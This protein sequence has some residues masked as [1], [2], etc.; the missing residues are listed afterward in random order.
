MHHTGHGAA[1]ACTGCRCSR[2]HT[3]VGLQAVHEGL[4]W[5]A[6]RLL[7]AHKSITKHLPRHCQQRSSTHCPMSA[8]MQH[9]SA[10]VRSAPGQP[11]WDCCCTVVAG[12]PR[13]AV[14]PLRP[15]RRRSA[16][17]PARPPPARGACWRTRGRW[18]RVPGRCP[19]RL[20]CLRGNSR[21]TIRV[22][23][24]GNTSETRLRLTAWLCAR[25]WMCRAAGTATAMRPAPT[26]QQS[27]LPEV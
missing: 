6:A 16:A 25:D 3:I 27:D 9:P 19:C 4:G 26:Q 8:H 10:H 2:T 20:P 22:Q 24:M 17:P 13:S 21:V 14:A 7:Q 15:G 5:D 11:A 12:T 1:M 23:E 18:R